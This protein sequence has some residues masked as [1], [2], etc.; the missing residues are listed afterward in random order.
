MNRPQAPRVGIWRA[1][2]ALGHYR[3]VDAVWPEVVCGIAIGVGGATLAIQSTDTATRI[4]IA[5]E[6]LTLAGVLLAVTFAALAW[7]R[8]HRGAICGFW[9]RRVTTACRNFLTPF[10]LQ[11]VLRLD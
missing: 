6:V 11:L 4:E 9:A 5:T 1:F 3:L 10:S 2:R 7:S 8:S